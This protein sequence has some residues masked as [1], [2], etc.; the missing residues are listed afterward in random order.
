MLCGGVG[1]G[2]DALLVTN[3]YHGPNGIFVLCI[4]AVLVMLRVQF[5]SR[6]ST[7]ARPGDFG[8]I[9]DGERG[10]FFYALRWCC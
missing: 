10:T 1:D 4:A 3:L 6:I 8:R 5:W 7:I 2:A 9:W